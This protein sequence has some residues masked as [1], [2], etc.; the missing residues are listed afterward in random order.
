[1]LSANGL[2]YE[3]RGDGEPVLLIH[4]AHISDSYR[5]LAADPSLKAFRKITYCRRGYGASEHHTGPYSITRTAQNALALLDQ[6]DIECAHIAGHSSGGVVALQMALA[7]PQIVR[8]LVLLEPALMMVPSATAFFASV[9][10]AIEKYSAGDVAAAVATFLAIFGRD[11][12]DTIL[13]TVPGGVAQAEKDAATFFEVEFFTCLALKAVQCS[14][15]ENNSATVG[16]HR[17]RNCL[18][19]GRT[20]CCNRTGAF[21]RSSRAA[22]ATSFCVIRSSENETYSINRTDKNISQHA[23]SG[24]SLLSIK[25]YGLSLGM[26]ATASPHPNHSDFA[27]RPPRENSGAKLRRNHRVTAIR[28][29]VLAV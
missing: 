12:R 28:E 21:R 27:R 10:P 8:S 26:S 19:K 24:R 3:I 22:C 1:M 20:T 17:W 11:W 13:G 25:G 15:T 23:T 4:G 5:A 18:W 2:D 9:S 29:N 16:C 6:L 7:A 14:K